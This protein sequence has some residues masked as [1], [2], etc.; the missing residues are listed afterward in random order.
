MKKIIGFLLAALFVLPLAAQKKK[1]KKKQETSEASSNETLN[2][3]AFKLRNIGPAL[4]SGRIADLAVDPRNSDHFYVAVASGG[5][6]E[7]KNNAVTWTPLF[8]S[9]SSF[10]TACVA[11]NP[12]N[13]NEVWVG[14]GEN[15]NQRS[16]GYGD[17][18]Y[19]SSDGG[20]SWEN[21]GLK[22]SEHIGMIAFDSDKP[23]RVF[24]AAY[25]P[26]WSSG[27]DRGIYRS[28]DS[29][30]TWEK[31][32]DA[33]IHT[34]FN[35]IHLHPTQKGLIFATAHQRARHVFTYLGGGPES[36]LYKSTDDGKTWDKV[37]SGLPS[38]DAGRLSL[39][40]SP[41][42][43]DVL[44]LLIE[45][46]GTYKSTDRGASWNKQSDHSTSG[47]YY[48]E[49]VAHPTELNTLYSLDTWCQ[50]SYDG[51]KSF[52]NMPEKAKHV[53]NHCIW[54]NP[55]NADHMR[56][57]CDGGFY[58]T[59]D[60]G[61]NW[62]FAANLPI[63]QFYRVSTDNALPFYN[64]YGGTQ[65]NF[66]LKGPSRTRSSHGIANSDWIVTNTGD[67][68][69]T[70]VD[71]KNENIV[72]AQA[73]YGWL[74]RFDA[75]IGE[76][77]SIKPIEP[78]NTPAWRW[79]WDAPLLIS[80]HNHE[81]LYFCANVV[82]KSDNRG[83][84]WE[85][86]SPDLSKGE[87]RNEFKIMERYWP[88]DAI[89]KNQSTSIYGNI[90]A[91]AESPIQEGL[92]FAGT[93]DGL[94]HIKQAGSSDWTKS[95]S[96]P[97]IPN[98]AYVQ[99]IWPSKHDK[100]VVYVAFNHHKYGDFKPYL[101]KSS[102][103]GKSWISLQSNL[104]ERGT[105][106]AFAEDHKNANLLFTGTE[107]GLFTSWDAGNDW[108]ALKS[109][110]P[111]VAVKDIEIQEREDDLVL[112]TFGRGFY[113]LDDYSPLREFEALNK[114]EAII[115]SV[116]TAKLFNPSRPLGYSGSGFQGA[117]FYLAPN[118]EI[119][120]RFTY[121]NP[122][123][124]KSLKDLR[125]EKEKKQFEEGV[126]IS[127][128]SGEELQ[129]EDLEVAPYL[130]L[131]ITDR[132]SKEI[133]R[134]NKPQTKGLSQWFWDGRYPSKEGVSNS[135]GK[136]ENRSTSFVPEGEYFAQLYAIDSRASKAIGAKQSFA[137]E[138]LEG[139][140]LPAKN[141]QNLAR[142]QRKADETSAQ[143]TLIENRVARLS[144]E[145]KHIR[146]NAMLMVNMPENSNLKLTELE[147]KI[148]NLK[149]KLY[150]NSRLQKL[151]F[152]TSP[153]IVERMGSVTWNSYFNGS[154][155]T[156]MQ[157]DNLKLV[158]DELPKLQNELNQTEAEAK[159]LYQQLVGNGM[160]E[161]DGSL[162]QR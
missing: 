135:G 46:H 85:V 37:K 38:A 5:V 126:V 33:G 92:L 10:S 7:T 142:F 45:G 76:E 83:N 115:F 122:E 118:P 123:I 158:G 24:V 155:P 98:S 143:L 93:D 23:N 103:G 32:L 102:D 117:G 68:F 69:E 152:E 19:R 40:I 8:D 36:A 26:L 65:D 130:Q 77:V 139:G 31:L 1:S 119:G 147:L 72:Y 89:A 64:V 138:Y 116:K 99:G 137:I 149:T 49:I 88:S 29:G 15:N 86:I 47:N 159:T 129:K 22:N 6:W 90:V 101:L 105:V 51:G 25:G 94:L 20:K 146:S 39:A 125:K 16:V 14:S 141:L 41:V 80:P 50:V 124:S 67:G 62:L 55:K 150:G 96:F 48:A 114:A 13:P 110:L 95:E 34:G 100:N 30:E 160:P 9:E 81:R 4:T 42:N 134:L 28:D 131:L 66:S 145:L 52:E 136:P 128:P 12:H 71:P 11:I 104:P 113:I 59:Y 60:R 109:G 43:P 58:Q 84:S 133:I 97:G 162:E 56:M 73:Q 132:N 21:M 70:Q 127:Y 107:F 74:V 18:I 57:G 2:L 53:D 151:E 79:N 78:L 148:D 121:Y 82:F 154:D 17:G 3:D 106:Y 108:K 35:E 144:K 75:S 63:T 112:A 157:I 61:E 87:N 156:A 44:F 54:I 120:V 27:G 111:T 153:G 91:F 140:Q 161:L